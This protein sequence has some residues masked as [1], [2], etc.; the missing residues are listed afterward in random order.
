MRKTYV[1]GDIHGCHRT[2]VELLEKIDPDPD[3]DF[4]IFLGD[5]IDRGPDSNLVVEE[6]IKLRGRFKRLVTLMGNHDQVFLRYLSGKDKDIFIAIGGEQTLK[7]YGVDPGFTGDPLSVIPGEHVFFFNDLLNY[8]EDDKY[9]Y[10]H[11]GLKPEVHI[12]QQSTEWLFW[13]R[14]RFID[15]KYDFGKRVI[16]GH[17]PFETPKIDKNKIGIDTGAVY[18]N[19]LTCLILPEIKFVRLRDVEIKNL[20]I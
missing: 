2:L 14:E 11:A 18:G 13:A 4:L 15:L 12:T 17:T 20:P 6:I 3:N 5:Y 1:I 9:I 8:W 10:V 7:S 19:H 16:Y